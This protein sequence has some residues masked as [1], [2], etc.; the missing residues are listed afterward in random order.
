M[1]IMLITHCFY[2][3]LTPSQGLLCILC[4]ASEELCNN[5]GGSTARTAD[6]TW[7]RGIACHRMLCP[8][9]KLER[10][11]QKPLIVVQGCD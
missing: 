3:M 8:V 9:Y 4:S 11:G 6:P 2:V 1:R 10:V 5:V 7:K